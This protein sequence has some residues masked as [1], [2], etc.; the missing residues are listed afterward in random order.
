MENLVEKAMGEPLGELGGGYPILQPLQRILSSRWVLALCPT[1][2]EHASL[3]SPGGPG[4]GTQFCPHHPGDTA[5]S[6]LPVM[7]TR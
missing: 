2:G 3:S 6:Q 7:R 1:H 5:L 4:P